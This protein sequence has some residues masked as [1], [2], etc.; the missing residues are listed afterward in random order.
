MIEERHEGSFGGE[1]AAH[2]SAGTEP[3]PAE[4]GRRHYALLMPSFRGG[5]AER[6]MVTLA[7]A[8]AARGH[9]IDLLVAKGE[10]PYRDEVDPRVTVHDLAA[11][12][13][14]SMLWPLK[15]YFRTARPTSILATMTHV[16]TITTLALLLSGHRARLILREA[17]EPPL[18]PRPRD[19][20]IRWTASWLYPRAD[21]MLS[22]APATRD[23][24]REDLNL[25]PSLPMPVI[26]NP[27]VTQRLLE[28]LAETPEPALPASDRPLFVA[29][30]R[31]VPAKGFIYLLDAF[32]RV[33]AVRPSRLVILG[34]G[35]QRGELE[36]MVQAHG[37]EARAFLP[38]FVA[39]PFA[40]MAASDAFVLSS[41]EEGSPNSLIQAMACDTEVVASL[42]PGSTDVLLDHGRHGRLVT[43]RDPAAL[44][45][46][47]LEA[48]DE[49]IRPDV[50]AWRRR[51]ASDG[52][53]DRYE[54][55][56]NEGLP[57]SSA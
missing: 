3:A 17:N 37:L 22:P 40:W 29:V 51:F 31:L 23:R 49:P 4:H 30:G 32:A 42:L 19:R 7:N 44:A 53:V 18:H 41:L 8:F 6:V 28:Q 45:E 34:E 9:R 25:P 38:G 27:A 43:P 35:V 39:N 24:N 54:A 46:A 5:G 56:L 1:I 21:A 13:V 55:L 50:H 48:L 26:D 52:I 33:N 20:L 16:N 14:F 36:A 47:M 15:R 12:R 57:T 2:G 10:G 11:A